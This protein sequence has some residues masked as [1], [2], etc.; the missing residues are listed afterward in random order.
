MSSP[1]SSSTDSHSPLQFSVIREEITEYKAVSSAM[2][3]VYLRLK[4]A[5]ATLSDQLD[6]VFLVFNQIIAYMFS[7]TNVRPGD[8]VQLEINSP[9]NN[10]ER[11]V[12]IT[13]R[14][15]DQLSAEVIVSIIEKILNSNEQ[16]LLAGPPHGKIE[17]N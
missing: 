6:W 7:D 3:N 14:R 1:S 15:G 17:Y 2:K 4:E 9:I 16:Y 13:P 10:P 8:R 11:P 12:F 5:P